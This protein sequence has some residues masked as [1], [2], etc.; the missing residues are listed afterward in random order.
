MRTQIY[1]S[2]DHADAARNAVGALLDHGAQKEDISLVLP[3]APDGKGVDS[4]DHGITT[5]TGSDAAVGA[6]KGAGIGLGIGALAAVASVLVPGIGLIAGGGA[7]ALALS[8]AAATTA[9]GALTGGVAGYL[10]DQGV[11][12]DIAGHLES[13][14]RAGG[15]FLSIL[16]PSGD[17]HQG[18]A[19]SLLAKYGDTGHEVWTSEPRLSE[20]VS[21][22]GSLD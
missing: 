14:I 20:P 18:L 19:M 11:P 16:V 21:R 17:V 7:L 8:G 15:A 4:A 5:T 22:G 10:Q 12:E 1:A 3:G 9:A 13:S 2:F 6:A